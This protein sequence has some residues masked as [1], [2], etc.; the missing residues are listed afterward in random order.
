MSFREP[1]IYCS[2]LRRGERG[3]TLLE[4]L[5]V[6][7]ILGFLAAIV[8][9]NVMHVQNRGREEAMQTEYHDVRIAVLTMMVKARRHQLDDGS[10]PMTV[11][12][13]DE[14]HAIHST[15]ETTGVI[16]YLDEHLISGKFPLMQAYSIKQNGDVTIAE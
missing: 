3:F 13:K 6:V 5:V 9:P 11:Q 14:C 8:I 10:Y 16:Y 15:D 12:T 7:A 4:I 2:W 1:V